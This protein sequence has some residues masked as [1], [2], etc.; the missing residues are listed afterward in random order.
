MKKL[1]KLTKK[2]KIIIG[3]VLVILAGGL[4]IF[5]QKGG[6]KGSSP[7]ISPTP[8]V[9]RIIP[10]TIGE[11]PHLVLTPKENNH[12]LVLKL[13]RVKNADGVEFELIYELEDQISRGISGK[14]DLMGEEAEKELMLGTCSSGTCRFDEGVTGGEIILNLLQGN[15]I[16]SLNAKFVIFEKES[17]SPDE[18]ITVEATK[19]GNF[20][21]LEGGGLPQDLEEGKEILGGPYTLTSENQKSLFAI[22]ITEGNL[23]YWDKDQWV[24]AEVEVAPL[25]T[26]LLVK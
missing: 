24:E 1:K 12:Y 7:T 22:T 11:M 4:I 20:L 16:R 2:Q 19:E 23:I 10:L 18:K 15:Q 5:L 9:N 8:Q 21:L 3:V 13:K 14:I 6:E 17:T 25:G 26:Y